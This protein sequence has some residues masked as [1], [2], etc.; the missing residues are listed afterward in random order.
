MGAVW[1]WLGGGWREPPLPLSEDV[2]EHEESERIKD[3]E[4]GVELG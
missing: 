2:M 1:G 4:L 3:L